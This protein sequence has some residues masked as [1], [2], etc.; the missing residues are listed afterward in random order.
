MD[1]VILLQVSGLLFFLF[2]VSLPWLFRRTDFLSMLRHHLRRF[3]PLYF[4]AGPSAITYFAVVP[5]ASMLLL[6]RFLYSTPNFVSV[7]PE[8]AN[9]HG[10]YTQFHLAELGFSFVGSLF[11][12]W[13]IRWVGLSRLWTILLFVSMSV[14]AAYRTAR[15][16]TDLHPGTGPQILHSPQWFDA[17]PIVLGLG[18]FLLLSQ[19]FNKPEQSPEELPPAT[20]DSVSFPQNAL[21][22]FIP[23]FWFTSIIVVVVTMELLW[24]GLF[25]YG[26][27]DAT[28][29]SPVTLLLFPVLLVVGIISH[30][31]FRNK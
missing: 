26:N 22:K 15:V 12:A 20:L 13:L 9:Q 23:R 4:V 6:L 2:L 16:G 8:Y 18:L 31:R 1:A 14:C 5:C 28:G 10:L 3:A 17:V 11:F 25:S 19:R 30:V 29:P 27:G 24:V 7:S 21:K